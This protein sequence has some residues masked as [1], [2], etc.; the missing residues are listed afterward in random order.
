MPTITPEQLTKDR[1]FAK[2]DRLSSE[3]L[4]ELLPIWN[5][6][7]RA[8]PRLDAK[9]S[10]HHDFYRLAAIRRVLLSRGIKV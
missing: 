8:A 4:L 10:K 2:Y 3:S 9:M 1:L 7:H 5:E 6:R